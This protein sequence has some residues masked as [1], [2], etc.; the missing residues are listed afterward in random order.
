MTKEEIIK[1]ISKPAIAFEVGGFKPDDNIKSSWIGKVLVGKIGEE[2]PHSNGKPMIPLCQINLSELPYKP[3]N[4]KDIALITVFIDSMEIPSNDEPNEI[5]WCLRTYES[6]NELI[7]LVQP[8]INSQIKPFQLKPRLVENDF[9]CHEDIPIELPEEF[10]DDY[11]DL[12]ENIGGIKIGGWPT[13]I[14]SKIF[15]APFNQH[16]AKPEYVFQIDSIEKA[17]WQWGD[18]GVG[19]FGRGTAD[20]KSNEWTFAWQCY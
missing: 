6:V 14:Q 18:G 16:P 11:Y 12:F 19:Y 9:P 2:W 5:N 20:G 13:L 10:E 3:D 7:S 1:Q 4:I 15:W 8:K 17:Q